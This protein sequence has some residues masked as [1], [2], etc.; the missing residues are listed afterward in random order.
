MLVP[1]ILQQRCCSNVILSVME[2]KKKYKNKMK[3]ALNTLKLPQ[4]AL[5]Y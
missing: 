4:A 3:T 5:I 2:K 1:M